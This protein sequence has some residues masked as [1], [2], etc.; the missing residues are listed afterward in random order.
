ML[1]FLLF[2][3]VIAVL[4]LSHEFGH[5]IVAK[6]KG[7]RVD[8]FGFGFP[9]RLFG[10]QHGETFYSF[11]LLPF[12]GFVKIWGEDDADGAN[13]PHN[14]AARSAWDRFLVLVAGVGI[15]FLFFLAFLDYN[16]F[17]SY[18]FI[19]YTLFLGVL[20]YVLFTIGHG[21]GIPG[22]VGAGEDARDAM[23]R[24]VDVIPGSPAAEAGVKAG[25][26][27]LEL[28][29]S[30]DTESSWHPVTVH[31]SEIEQVQN[32]VKT[33]AGGDITMVV[34]RVNEELRLPI[35]LRKE[36]P[37][38][39]GLLGIA[40]AKVGIIRT[41]WYRAPWEGLLTTIA[42]TK[43][44]AGGLAFFFAN[45]VSSDV[46]NS[47]AGPVGIAKVAGQA[48]ALGFAYLLQLIAVLSINLAILNI[49]PIPA[50]DGGR[51]LFLI[52]EK[53]RGKPIGV[54]VSQFAHTSGFIVLILLM[55]V[56][57]YFDLTKIF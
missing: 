45:I 52:I 7:M 5:F 3:L 39:E 12:G 19:A 1:T 16:I 44:V 43:F 10:K 56:V 42:T 24:V 34:E 38:G 46:I 28:I 11:N 41:A 6:W 21:I 13:D 4:V 9:P 8:E 47:V 35:R 23:V 30:S 57:T 22:V 40:M 29:P 14:F 2:L 20:A 50:L 33:H 26:S 37:A 53:L 54:R 17:R 31:V 36:A 51:V 48:S 15:V 32:F 25:D 18:A 55:L 49:L 27:I